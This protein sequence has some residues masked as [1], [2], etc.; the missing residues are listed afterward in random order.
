MNK[1][2]KYTLFSIV[3][4]LIFFRILN[5]TGCSLI[6]NKGVIH[7]IEIKND[8]TV[9]VKLKPFSSPIGVQLKVT[10]FVEDTCSFGQL[11][12]LPK[13]RIDT[14]Y[15]YDYYNKEIFILNYFKIKSKKSNLKI[16]Y[17]L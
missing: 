6:Q 4:S 11:I 2:L 17:V 9:R 1:L 16:E 5:K 3:F 8:T 13:G 7:L 12:V 15:Q 14:I 10:G